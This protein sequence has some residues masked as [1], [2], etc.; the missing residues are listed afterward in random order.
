M[1]EEEAESARLLAEDARLLAEGIVDTVREPL[2]VLD[3]ELKVI[4]ANHSFYRS[5]NT[6]QEETLQRR[7]YDI[8][9]GQW[10]IA[11]LRKLLEQIIPE[12]STFENFVVKHEFP[13]IGHKVM[14]LNARQI[15][16]DKGR[17]AKILLAIR[18]VTEDS[19]K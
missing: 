5:F 16:F 1:A 14:N 4:S 15:N 2:L 19:R 3:E 6:T 13:M 11:P 10:N 9:S 12:N 17:R 18:D 8:G 7:I